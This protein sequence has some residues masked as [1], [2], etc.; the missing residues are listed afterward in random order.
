[1]AVDLRSGS[2]IE[3]ALTRVSELL[4]A[5]GEA[6]A[7]VILGGAALNLLGVVTRTTTDVDI[8][9]V[10]RP[11]DLAIHREI[12]E[13]PI[14]LPESLQR[15]IRLV[16]QDMSL[17]SDWL[18]TGPAL[19]W[20]TG[21][22]PGLAGRI[23]WRRYGNALDVGI[24]GRYDLIFFKL[25]A[26]ADDFGPAGVHYQDLIALEPTS[27]ELLAAGAWVRGQD[28]SS[29]FAGILEQVITHVRRHF[30][31]SERSFGGAE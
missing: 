12:S 13:P 7:I 14:P 29:E 6:F 24:V 10:A 15:A 1:M 21:L 28:A 3:A 9:A 23:Q 26:A 27:D 2:D 16:A 19:Q 4:D 18:N 17:A 31:F 20:R 30:R 11:G 22:P 25:F 5:D 8:L